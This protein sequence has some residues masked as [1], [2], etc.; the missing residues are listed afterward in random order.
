[1]SLTF[2]FSTKMRVSHGY[3]ALLSA[4]LCVLFVNAYVPGM[5]RAI[6]SHGV[7]ASIANT[8]GVSFVAILA[9]YIIVKEISSENEPIEHISS[10]LLGVVCVSMVLPFSV[11]SWFGVTCIGLF[12]IARFPQQSRIR[13]VASIIMMLAFHAQWVKYIMMFFREYILY[14]D[15][16]L[17]ASLLGLHQDGNLITSTD[18]KTLLQVLEACSSFN[19]LSVALLGFSVV[20]L[21]SD[22]CSMVRRLTTIGGVLVSVI[23]I[24]TVRI[25]LIAWNPNLY[26]IVHGPVG[27]TIVN[28]LSAAVILFGPY[29]ALNKR[30]SRT[31]DSTENSEGDGSPISHRLLALE[32]Q[33]IDVPMDVKQMV[34]ERGK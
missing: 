26:D 21:Y 20:S 7:V 24:N 2:L 32:Y 19:N 23:G 28:W 17:V 13:G 6:G 1:M 29:V 34:E 4:L 14:A 30:T 8:F 16:F 5:M 15:A 9:I 31:K 33:A 3:N 25:G 11:S 22:K 18:S 27:A 12:L 10:W